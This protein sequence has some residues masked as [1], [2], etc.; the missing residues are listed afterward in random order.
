MLQKAEFGPA[1]KLC[2]LPYDPKEVAVVLFELC[3]QLM[4]FLQ[5]SWLVCHAGLLVQRACQQ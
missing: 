2:I 5:D 4:G 3:C 1:G